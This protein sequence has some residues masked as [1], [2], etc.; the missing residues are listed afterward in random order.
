R[1]SASPSAPTGGLP[2]NERRLPRGAPLGRARLLLGLRRA[3]RLR[4]RI[5]DARRGDAHPHPLLGPVQGRVELPRRLPLLRRAAGG[6]ERA[7]LRGLPLRL[8]RAAP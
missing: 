7:L 6:R 5:P 4:T 2:P 1:P 3:H 8:P